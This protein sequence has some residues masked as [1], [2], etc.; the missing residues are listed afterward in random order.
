M[1]SQT[2]KKVVT[3]EEKPPGASVGAG[4][5]SGGRKVFGISVPPSHADAALGGAQ[6]FREEEYWE[7][8]AAYSDLLSL[9]SPHASKTVEE[10]GD[11]L[12]Q[13][14]QIG[15]KIGGGGQCSAHG[16]DVVDRIGG[17]VE[18]YN[19]LAKLKR[20]MD[21]MEL[22]ALLG[23]Q[24]QKPDLRKPQGS[25]GIIQAQW[26]IG[27]GRAQRLLQHGLTKLE[28][29]VAELLASV[30]SGTEKYVYLKAQI[31]HMRQTLSETIPRWVDEELGPKNPEG[32]PYA[33]TGPGAKQRYMNYIDAWVLRM[34]AGT[35]E[36]LS[37]MDEGPVIIE[38]PKERIAIE[39]PTERPRYVPLS[40]TT[41]PLDVE[42]S[43]FDSMVG[44]ARTEPYQP[45]PPGPR[46][47]TLVV[48]PDAE[49][50]FRPLRETSVPAE[51]GRIGE[52]KVVQL[53]DLSPMAYFHEH[54]DI[55][56]EN[57]PLVLPKLKAT[58]IR[59]A[60]EMVSLWGTNAALRFLEGQLEAIQAIGERRGEV[61]PRSTPFT[62]TPP[63]DSALF[64]VQSEALL[65][66][67]PE[68]IGSLARAFITQATELGRLEGT[69]AALRHLE[70]QLKS[71]SRAARVRSSIAV[72]KIFGE[73]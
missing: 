33:L 25:T 62:R 66:K 14:I 40:E 59:Q 6:V 39:V 51:V 10:A 24:R 22:E 56:A 45:E 44:H 21:L 54:A 61:V 43:P 50:L 55:L 26:F 70:S 5:G 23:A 35:M 46:E 64:T 67:H 68:V 37:A 8:V 7:C 32:I 36:T 19:R 47:R 17:F 11:K 53:Q 2:I 57:Y 1:Q 72:H 18:K 20:E 34:V 63:F 60:A 3:E 29:A 28:E 73:Q 58:F 69:E 71:I 38:A 48:Q 15:K 49:P 42:R 4:R 16:I 12:R 13:A 52:E 41:R 31:E 65:A 30:E 9:G 27:E